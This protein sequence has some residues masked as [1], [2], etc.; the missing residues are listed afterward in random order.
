M[1]SET[2]VKC[3]FTLFFLHF[4]LALNLHKLTYLCPS[5]ILLLICVSNINV[6]KNKS[7][8]VAEW[9]NALDEDG[10]IGVPWLKSAFNLHF[11]PFS[12]LSDAL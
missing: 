6:Y 5:M 11:L 8:P 12:G 4:F 1:K 10:E 3:L 2:R 7:I 9:S